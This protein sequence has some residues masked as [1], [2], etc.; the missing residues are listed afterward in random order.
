LTL[1]A[2]WL[3]IYTVT[4]NIQGD[5]WSTITQNVIAGKKVVEPWTPVRADFTFGG[6]YKDAAYTTKWDFA[7]D[8]VSGNTTLYAKW[9]AVSTAEDPPVIPPT[10]GIS[11]NQSGTYA[12]PTVTEGY[13]AQTAKSV[14]INN[15]GNQATGA[16]TIALSSSSAFILSA[17]SVSSIAAGGSN[18]FTIR[19][20]L[21]LPAGTYTA[22]VT[23]SAASGNTTSIASKSFTVSFTVNAP[24]NYGIGL[25]VT[26][27]YT[28]PTATVGYVAQTAKSVTVSNTGNQPTGSL[29]VAVSD[30]DSWTLSAGTLSSIAAGQQRTFTIKP[31]LGLG[32]GTHAATVTISGGSDISASFTVSF[33][34][35]APSAPANGFS[36]VTEAI[37]HLTTQTGGSY[38]ANPISLKLNINLSSSTYGWYPLVVAIRDSGK[39]VALDISGST[40]I[41]GEFDSGIYGADMVQAKIVSLVLPDSATALIGGS[42]SLSSGVYAKLKTVSGANITTIGAQAFYRCPYLTTVSF[43]NA[44]SI[45]NY[46]FYGFLSSSLTTVSFPEATSIGYQA[47]YY[48]TSLTTASFPKATSIGSYAFYQCYSLTTASFPEATSIGSYAFSGTALTTASL[49]EATTIGA[50][51]FQNCTAL[52]T[53]SIPKAT[54][55]GSS[56]FA[57]SGRGLLTITMGTAAPTVG[58]NMFDNI[59]GSRTVTIRVPSG[60]TGYTSAWQTAFKS[61]NSYIN[62]VIQYY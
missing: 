37:T 58:S 43:P 32:A 51:A 18:S 15:T 13:G 14:T 25:S 23:V 38:A 61:G 29:T 62:L 28:F 56:A 46:A 40:V 12:F 21:N 20:N 39:Y 9:T 16:L 4:F 52:T 8:T 33:T 54:S 55:I 3:T 5:T 1:Y 42:E 44:T 26:D 48:C 31:K 35:S 53:V 30:T 17:T 45:G 50:Y 11:L 57:A 34:V 60:A 49:P 19:P 10:Y 7:T 2:K 6:W 59:N 22:T 47:F 41:N 36:T 24:A 27:S